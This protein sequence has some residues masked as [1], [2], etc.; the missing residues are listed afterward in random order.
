MDVRVCVLILFSLIT[1]TCSEPVKY[2]DCGSR[3]GKVSIVEITPCPVLPCPLHKGQDY[4]VNV[5]FSSGVDTPT[6]KAL[7]HG[8]IAGVPIPFAIPV[9]DGCKCGIQCPIQQ[10]QVYHYLNTLPVKAQYPNTGCEVGTCRQQPPGPLLHR[11][12]S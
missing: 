12:P 2:L 3:S 7:V 5:T 10:Q 9:D 8:I 1:F 11:V 6:S 4:S